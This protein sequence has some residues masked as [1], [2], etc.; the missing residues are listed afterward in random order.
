M[1]IWTEF[2]MSSVRRICLRQRAI[3]QMLKNE[4]VRLD[5]SVSS[6]L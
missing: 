2:Q 4:F 5:V 3:R 1:W 6:A